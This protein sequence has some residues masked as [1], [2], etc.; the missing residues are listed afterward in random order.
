MGGGNRSING[1]CMMKRNRNS[2]QFSAFNGGLVLLGV[3]AALLLVGC[4]ETAGG[5]D[6]AGTGNAQAEDGDDEAGTG[7]ASVA[8]DAEVRDTDAETGAG[9]AGADGD[10]E[11]RDTDVCDAVVLPGVYDHWSDAD[12]DAE[13]SEWNWY[14][15]SPGACPDLSG[16]FSVQNDSFIPFGGV[17]TPN[18][19]VV[20]SGCELTVE[21]PTP[22]YHENPNK[23][24]YLTPTL[25]LKAS[26]DGK[27]LLTRLDWHDESLIPF[28]GSGLD[29][30][31]LGC[32]HS[33]PPFTDYYVTVCRTG[34][35]C[36]E[37]CLPVGDGWEAG[38]GGGDADE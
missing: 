17:F 12:G 15:E 22:V 3:V 10:A 9:T 34:D 33:D 28:Y 11:V 2:E 25:Q 26:P 7:N 35:A 18:I 4:L 19:T 30:A 13:D 31:G 16:C 23:M 6:T 38:E 29:S 20:Q 36:P 32:W 21:C 37:E 5:N 24:Q 14:C 27:V 1:R 8:G